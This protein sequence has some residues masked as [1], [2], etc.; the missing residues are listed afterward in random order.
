MTMKNILAFLAYVTLGI[1][2]VA[3][4]A[5]Y[6]LGPGD[7]VRITVYDNEDMTTED[8]ITENG[9]ITMPLLGQLNLTG[10]T[11]VGAEAY[12]QKVL[13]DKKL[14]KSPSVTVRVVQYRSQLISVVGNV[15]KPGTYAIE[16]DSSLLELIALA[17][18]I[19][20][21]GDDRVSI[22]RM[23]NGIPA[24]IDV[25]T[26]TLLEKGNMSDNV[27]V[28]AGDVIFVPKAPMFYVYGEV[29]RPG[30]Y[31]LQRDMTVLQALSVGGGLTPRGT[32]RGIKINRR[33]DDGGT[34][35]VDVMLSERLKPDDVITVKERLF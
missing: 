7:V 13:E 26:R 24:K 31:R 19:A 12:I 14:V 34:R 2:S 32:E 15:V 25:D 21:D 11:K 10:R 27:E 33:A 16:K 20:P 6:R 23:E 4:A 35:T 5:E 9:E 30:A 17:G 8:R 1:C 29:Q 18:G 3:Q 28:L 22:I